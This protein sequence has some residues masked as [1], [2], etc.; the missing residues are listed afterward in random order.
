MS[1]SKGKF[2]HQ[3]LYKKQAYQLIKDPCASV[4]CVSCDACSGKTLPDKLH[5]T[6]LNKTGDCACLPD[7]FVITYTNTFA[8]PVWWNEEWSPG[9]TV[10]LADFALFCWNGSVDINGMELVNFIPG[11]HPLLGS[12]CNPLFLLF[13]GTPVGLTGD[14]DIIITD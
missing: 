5:V 13:H 14:C 1:P 3:W 12:T 11:S 8:D 2:V 10:T 6:I 4:G 7:D 9:C